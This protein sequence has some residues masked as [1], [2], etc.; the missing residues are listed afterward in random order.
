MWSDNKKE[1]WEEVEE[2]GLG[3]KDLCKGVG[4]MGRWRSVLCDNKKGVV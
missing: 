4:D 3:E 2:L 1:V